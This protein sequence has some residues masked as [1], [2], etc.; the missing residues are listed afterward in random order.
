MER[1]C[2]VEDRLELWL[3]DLRKLYFRGDKRGIKKER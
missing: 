2:S 1:E 3:M